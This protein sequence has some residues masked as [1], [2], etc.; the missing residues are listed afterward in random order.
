MNVIKITLIISS[1]D[2]DTFDETKFRE[3]VCNIFNLKTSESGCHFL[4]V[5]YMSGNNLL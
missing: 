5:R 3:T 2:C 1:K 4:A